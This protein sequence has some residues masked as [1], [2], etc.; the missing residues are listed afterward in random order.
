MVP[1]KTAAEWATGGQSFLDNTPGGVS[2]AMCVGGGGLSFNQ[3]DVGPNHSCAIG[4]DERAY[5]WGANS[6]G[7]LGDGTTSPRNV[8]V[9]V[10]NGDNTA[11]TYKEIAVE[12]SFTCAVGTDDSIYC[13][14]N[15]PTGAFS[16]NNSPTPELIANGANT[17]GVF[18]SLAV[19]AAHI[20]ALGGDERAYCWGSNWW[21]L[22][23]IGQLGDGTTTDRATP[24]L[25]INGA[26]SSG[27]YKK[28]VAGG[29]KTCAIGTDDEAYC[30][31]QGAWGGLGDGTTNNRTSPVN[32]SN[33]SNAAGTY[34]D[35]ST[36][37]WAS[38]GIGTDDKAYCW[39]YGGTGLM[40]NGT[41]T[42]TNT[43]PVA[44]SNGSNASGTYKSIAIS[45]YTACGVAF[46]DA[47]HCWGRGTNGELG[48]GSSSDS[49]VPVSVSNG[50]NTDGKYAQ[51]AL[52]AS[53]I[54]GPAVA[55][56]GTDAKAYFWGVNN[57]SKFGD[58]TTTPSNTPAK[59][60]D[61][62]NTAGTWGA[63]GSG[64]PPSCTAADTTPDAFSFTDQTDVALST[65]TTSNSININ[66]INTSTPVSVSGDGSPEIRING[67]SWATSGSIT[68]GQSLEVRLT[69]SGSNSTAHTA[70]VDVGGVT[71]VWSVTTASACGGEEV[72]GYCWYFGAQNQSCDD[73]C[74]SHG[75]V[76]ML[77]TRNYAGFPEGSD[78]ACYE[79]T[80]AFSFTGVPI[81][82]GCSVPVGCAA[83]GTLVFRCNGTTTAAA[84]EG[85]TNRFCACNS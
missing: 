77:G 11:G 48:N 52:N 50:D 23:P 40:G 2:L 65:I 78:L 55:S 20:C 30:W 31:G 60:S 69:S 74:A 29:S 10:S 71:D 79:V 35:I 44:V 81:L 58:A 5:C 67:G 7:Q 17:T 15:I 12:G 27:T 39:G 75:G 42:Q 61:G 9:L 13:W 62:A 37:G 25:V 28:I 6:A 84:K 73:V 1:T 54:S 21:G 45:A 57:D 36:G 83:I 33:G 47:A 49:S 85:I 56:I 18:S 19:G 22:N 24:T 72:G 82:G 16:F 59:T 51:I 64:A 63:S 80:Q 43:S 32:V 34:K 53:N 8:P 76:N 26:N 70:T 4:S 66:G 46:D 68:D 41:T 14:G 3:I 38:C